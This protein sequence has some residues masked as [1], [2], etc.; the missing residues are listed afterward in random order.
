MPRAY[1]L[2]GDVTAPAE[3][4]P[5]LA[6]LETMAQTLEDA[7]HHRAAAETLEFLAEA[8]DFAALTEMRLARLRGVWNAVEMTDGP[9]VD[10][11]ERTARIA[12][13]NQTYL[14]RA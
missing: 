13:A 14:G 4:F 12:T 5:R 3:V 8:R 10:A 1:D 11:G 9:G 6:A 7:G 2:V